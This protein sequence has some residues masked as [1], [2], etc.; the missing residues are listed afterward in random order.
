MGGGADSDYKVTGTDIFRRPDNESQ[1]DPSAQQWVRPWLP[2]EKEAEARGRI[3]DAEFS[4]RQRAEFFKINDALDE[5]R[6]SGRFSPEEMAELE[7]Q[8][9]IQRMGIKAMPKPKDEQPKPIIQPDA[10]GREWIYQNGKWDRVEDG[11]EKDDGGRQFATLMKFVPETRTEMR[12]NPQTGKMEEAEVPLSME[13]RVAE[14]KKLRQMY[15]E[16]YGRSQPPTPAAQPDGGATDPFIQFLMQGGASP[17]PDSLAPAPAVSA[18]PVAAPAAQ[19]VDADPY[20]AFKEQPE[21]K[22]EGR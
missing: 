12:R 2:G 8:A 17:M 1:W 21:R 16:F 5:A 18:A 4:S 15:D 22:K 11:T 19:P 6:R 3:M 13:E 9:D 7:R 20:A 14:L 10:Q